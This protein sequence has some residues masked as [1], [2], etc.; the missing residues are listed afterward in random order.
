MSQYSVHA[1]SSWNQAAYRSSASWPTRAG[2]NVTA[3]PL[4]PHR[5]RLAEGDVAFFKLAHVGLQLLLD[6]GHD[7][8]DHPL[9]QA[10]SLE[11]TGQPDDA[12]GVLKLDDGLGVPS[13]DAMDLPVRSDPPPAG[14]RTDP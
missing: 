11:L 9:P 14:I 10:F 5:G 2:P 3:P 12:D 7:R 1:S 4:A 8:F 6:E 13:G